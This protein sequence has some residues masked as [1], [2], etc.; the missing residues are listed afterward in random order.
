MFT[1]SRAPERQVTQDEAERAA[2]VLAAGPLNRL[3]AEDVRTY[4][5]SAIRMVHPDAGGGDAAAAPDR[6]KELRAARD[7]LMRWMEGQPDPKCKECR[8][9]GYVF[10]RVAVKPC[11]RCGK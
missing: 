2:K 9:T 1:P 11:S 7:T 10:G 4:F 3:T 6:L 8:G 5:R